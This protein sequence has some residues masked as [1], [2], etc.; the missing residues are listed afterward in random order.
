MGGQAGEGTGSSPFS[1]EALSSKHTGLSG[2]SLTP[3]QREIPDAWQV[4]SSSDSC[5]SKARRALERVLVPASGGVRNQ[6]VR[7]SEGAQ[8]S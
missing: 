8:I 7:V 4:F 2:K 5:S 1:A 3:D 6:E